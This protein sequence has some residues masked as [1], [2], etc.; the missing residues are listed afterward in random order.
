MVT[1]KSR[2]M[3]MVFKQTKNYQ[4]KRWLLI[5]SLWDYGEHLWNKKKTMVAMSLEELRLI[6]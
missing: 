1:K 5:L 2:T 3:F 4:I 6:Y